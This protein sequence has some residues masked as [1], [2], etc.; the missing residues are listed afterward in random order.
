MLDSQE[1]LVLH[2]RRLLLLLEWEV[3]LGEASEK[4]LARVQKMSI[5]GVSI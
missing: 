4:A 2:R 5:Q 1:V 3:E